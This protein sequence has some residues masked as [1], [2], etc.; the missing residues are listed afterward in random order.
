MEF[1]NDL[2]S[3][4]LDHQT[5]E[6]DDLAAYPQYLE[7]IAQWHQQQWAH[8][9]PGETLAL[10]IQRMQGYLLNSLIPTMY[11][12]QQNELLLG[13]AMIVFDEMETHPELNPWLASV[14][15]DK[16]NRQQGI[17]SLLVRHVMAKAKNHNIST[18][19]LYTPDQAPFYQHLG[20][21]TI[22]EEHLH[23]EPVTL[24]KVDF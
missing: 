13:S 1:T 12:A 9:N 23:A 11:I 8:L 14:Y 4:S 5:I 17:G 7:T 20:W 24:M 21:K 10:R 2:P 15:V 16:N 3:R 19:Y 6:I 18:L 22:S